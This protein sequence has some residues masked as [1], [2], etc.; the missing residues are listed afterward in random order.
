MTQFGPKSLVFLVCSCIGY[1]V[2]HYLPEPFGAY[3]RILVPYHLFLLYLVFME[4]DQAGFSMPIGQTIVTHLACLALLVGIAMGRRY[5]PFFGLIGLFVP[6]LAPFEAEWL[7]SGS[8]KPVEEKSQPVVHVVEP[9]TADEYSEFMK[10]MSGSKREF[11]KL[12]ISPKDE[13]NLWRAAK[14]KQVNSEQ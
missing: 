11:K 4:N 3:L 8:G 13:Y 5:V 6:A 10:Y 9:E 2:A 1:F 14:L 7:F 12:G